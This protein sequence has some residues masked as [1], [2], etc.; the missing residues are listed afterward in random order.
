MPKFIMAALA[1]LRRLPVARYIKPLWKGG[2]K[3]AVASGGDALQAEL[4]RQIAERGEK[5][6][7]GI[8]AKL[9]G[10]QERLERAVD[11]L[12]LPAAMEDRIKAA[13][14]GPVDALQERLRAGCAS[15]CIASAQAA[16]DAAFDR[17][18]A[19]VAAAIDR[20]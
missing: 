7:E 13:L 17:F 10:L 12:P 1:A 18:Q 15:G 20:L 8:D 11:G 19:E 14:N 9:D 3:M 5:A 4:N 6:L 2:L 16:F